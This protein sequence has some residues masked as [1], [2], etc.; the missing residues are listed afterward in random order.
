MSTK[1]GL[2]YV[3]AF[4]VGFWAVA[5]GSPREPGSTARAD[6]RLVTADAR[7]SAP[8]TM[9]VERSRF[10]DT[11][12]VTSDGRCR[13][14]PLAS[15]PGDTVRGLIYEDRVSPSRPPSCVRLVV[16]G[17]R[18]ARPALDTSDGSSAAITRSIDAPSL[19]GTR[20]R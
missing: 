17:Y 8:D 18:K 15:A 20:G 9:F 10:E 12:S 14:E 16:R 19:P 3:V 1:L 7:S 5:C 2:C 13:W 4:T 11:G 6:T